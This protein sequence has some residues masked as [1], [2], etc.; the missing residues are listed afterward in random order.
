MIV[1]EGMRSSLTCPLIARDKRVGFIFFS[2]LERHTYREVHTEIFRQIA[3]Q[4]SPVIEKG[5]LY[6]QLLEL[7]QELEKRNRFIRKQ[8]G[9]Y[10]SDSV[11]EELLEPPVS[12]AYTVLDGKHFFDVEQTGTLER[13]SKRQAWVRFEGPVADFTN[14]RLLPIPRTPRLLVSLLHCPAD[15]LM[16]IDEAGQ[17]LAE[18]RRTFDDRGD[19]NACWNG[20]SSCLLE[21][22]DEG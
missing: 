5:E 12:F 9:W 4:I 13:I 11:V 18:R 7:T 20:V 1:D 22:V 8:F 19:R 14:L 17:I 21:V 6:Q 2:S 15:G 16:I 10:I 3:G